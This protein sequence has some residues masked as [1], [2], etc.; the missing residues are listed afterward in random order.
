ML[1]S[2][3]TLSLDVASQLI[4]LYVMS[5]AKNGLANHAC[6]CT[7]HNCGEGDCY[8]VQ[9][10]LP[11]GFFRGRLLFDVRLLFEEIRYIRYVLEC[12]KICHCYNNLDVNQCA[13]F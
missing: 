4:F 8:Y 7:L 6:A 10:A 13:E 12:V 11:A 1:S 9:L 3:H 2:Q 5:L